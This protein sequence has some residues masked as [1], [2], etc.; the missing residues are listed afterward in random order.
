M[1]ATARPSSLNDIITARDDKEEKEEQAI[2]QE[3]YYRSL[4]QLIDSIIR[5]FSREGFNS[6]L[7][8][9]A[10]RNGKNSQDEIKGSISYLEG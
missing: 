6:R 7:K 10:R 9:L 4:D 5:D 1:N 3:D 2:T 8:A